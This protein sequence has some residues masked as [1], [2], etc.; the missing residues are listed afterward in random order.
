MWTSSLFQEV[1]V[2]TIE[3]SRAFNKIARKRIIE[4]NYRVVQE[5]SYLH[6]IIQ[7]SGFGIHS[8]L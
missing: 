8:I 5:M 6:L 2:E 4:I 7:F 3:N 1:A